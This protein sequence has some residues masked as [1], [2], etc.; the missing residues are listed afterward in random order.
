ML[1]SLVGSEMCIRDRYMPARNPPLPFQLVHLQYRRVLTGRP[2]ANCDLHRLAG[3]KLLAQ[4]CHR[5]ACCRPPAVQL[6][7]ANQRSL[8]L[9]CFSSRHESINGGHLPQHMRRFAQSLHTHVSTQYTVSPYTMGKLEMTWRLLFPR[10]PVLLW[11]QSVSRC[12]L[13]R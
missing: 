11:D 4:Q 2:R 5:N 7:H 9:P 6:V 13:E 12:S 10:V 8:L 3:V 1:R